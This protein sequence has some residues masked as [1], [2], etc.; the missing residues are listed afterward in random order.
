MT[1]QTVY[2]EECLQDIPAEDIYWEDDRLFC[3]RC[4]GR[5]ESPDKDISEEIVD[6]RTGFLFQDADERDDEEAED[7][8][9]K[10]QR[11]DDREGG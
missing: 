7:G 3:G 8:D 9:L 11:E 2:C 5:L 10:V 1:E 6:N 4:G